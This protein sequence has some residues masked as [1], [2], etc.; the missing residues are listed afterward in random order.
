MIQQIALAAEQQSVATQQI[1]GDLEHVAK[2]SKESAGGAAESAKA[3][4]DLSR[5][6]TELQTIVGGFK[7]A[8]G[9]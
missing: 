9:K 5:L 6:A 2:V 8:D 7:I 4:Q 3:S 1:A